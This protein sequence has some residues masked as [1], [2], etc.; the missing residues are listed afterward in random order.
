M[1]K[2]EVVVVTGMSGAGKTQAMAIF[3]N[4]EY[5]CIDNYP[6]ALLKEFGD[7]LRTSTKYS[8]VAMAVSL[9]DAIL[10]VRVLSNMDWVDLT[11]IF[12]DC[13]DEVLLSRYKQTRRSHP[14]MISNVTS[15]LTEAI[16]F[17]REMADPISK[18]ANIV[19]DTTLLKPSKLQ[20]K[21]EIYFHK[22]NQNT[23]RVSFVSFGYKHGV[24]RDAD[25]LLDVRFLPNPFYI[26]E[27][28]SLT[29]NDQ[30]VYDYVMN[31][32][33]TA[34][35]IEKTITYYDYLL[36]K[37]EEEGK[38]QMIIGIGC[39]GGQ[40]RSVTLTNYFADYYSKYYQV[41]KWHRDADH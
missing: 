35:F 38:M 28:R 32:P 34:E 29:G 25:L 20:D 17:E 11:V 13:E 30:A 15:S 31:Q 24:P 37:Y 14:L 22:G 26:E 4:M 21:L 9:G 12:L 33:E 23:F 40:H 19:I 18:L 8:K 3:E 7:L 27:L 41:Y 5:R 1:D 6:V 36:K 16:E 10:A 2:I 39:T